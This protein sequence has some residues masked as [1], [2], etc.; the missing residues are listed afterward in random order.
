MS[1]P[2]YVWW[3]EERGVILPDHGDVVAEQ[4]DHGR[5]GER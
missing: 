1:T 4:I 5:R 3:W 2:G